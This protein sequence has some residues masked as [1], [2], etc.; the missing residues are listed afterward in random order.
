MHTALRGIVFSLI[1]IGMAGC[2]DEETLFRDSK[3]TDP[4]APSYLE[5]ISEN[6][7]LCTQ[8]TAGFMRQTVATP[9]TPTM[10]CLPKPLPWEPAPLQTE[11]GPEWG[12]IESCELLFELVRVGDDLDDESCPPELYEGLSEEEASAYLARKEVRVDIRGGEIA[13]KVIMCPVPKLS[14]PLDCDEASAYFKADDPEA[15]GWYYC[16]A[17]DHEYCVPHLQ[18]TIPAETMSIGHFFSVGC[19]QET[20]LTEEQCDTSEASQLG[21]VCTQPGYALNPN[22]ANASYELSFQQ[23]CDCMSYTQLLSVQ[24]DEPLEDRVY[25]AHFCTQ[26]CDDLPCPGG[27]QCIETIPVSLAENTDRSYCIPDCMVDGCSGFKS[28]ENGEIIT[29]E[30]M[31][32][33][34][35]DVDWHCDFPA[36]GPEGDADTDADTD[37]DTDGDADSDADTDTDTDTDGDADSDADSD[38]DTDDYL[39]IISQSGDLCTHVSTPV[40]RVGNQTMCY[41]SPMEWESSSECETCGQVTPSCELVV[42][43][44]RVGGEMADES[45]PAE[46][47]DHLS[48]AEREAYLDKKEVID[49]EMDEVIVSRIVLCPVPKLSTPID[50][51]DADLVAAAEQEAGW[52]YCEAASDDD[53]P[54]RVHLTDKASE[55]AT[56]HLVTTEC[57]RHTELTEDACDATGP[58]VLGAVCTQPGYELNPDLTS[59][60][61][62]LSFQQRCDCMTKTDILT[63]DPDTSLEERL[64]P[65][66][67][68]TQ[69]CDIMECPSGYKCINPFPIIAELGDGVADAYCVPDCVAEGCVGDRDIGGKVEVQQC[70]PTSDTD[71]DW[72]CVFPSDL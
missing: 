1:T 63:L 24:T 13:K 6:R 69:P 53:C 34:D 37:G 23:T 65:T 49:N 70:L 25:D 61:Y 43:V 17:P 28:G 36:T 8:V 18:L 67:F 50:C 29:E 48:E 16:E 62:E 39:D 54:Y 19:L 38:A 41:T 31:V 27:Y 3:S 57:A 30:C 47:Y 66:H 40:L 45:C 55:I 51:S 12:T 64:V 42:E 7:E 71:A 33:S 2:I 58:S 11:E 46:L 9:T 56:G 21:A 15:V 22:L 52:Y 72:R 44:L 10:T 59:S 60:V 35:T 4:E 20:A 5:I 68:C 26:P 14:S 32:S